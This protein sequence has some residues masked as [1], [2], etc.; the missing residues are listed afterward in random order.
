MG[1][2]ILSFL[3]PRNEKDGNELLKILPG[4]V[5]PCFGMETTVFIRVRNDLVN[6]C[7]FEHFSPCPNRRVDVDEAA[8]YPGSVSP[9]STVQGLHFLKF[10]LGC[11]IR[12]IEIYSIFPSI[13]QRCTVTRFLFRGRRRVRRV[14]IVIIYGRIVVLSLLVSLV[15]LLPVLPPPQKQT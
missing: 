2:L 7:S 1:R 3:Y 15:L 10:F 5:R 13:S 4:N 14:G 8:L 9:T 12:W 11:W 6:D